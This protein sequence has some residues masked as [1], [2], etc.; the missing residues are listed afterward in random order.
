MRGSILG[1]ATTEPAV[2]STESSGPAARVR[3]RWSRM[4]VV[5][6][7]AVGVLTLLALL[8]PAL[9]P[10]DPTEHHLGD[11]P[12]LLIGMNVAPFRD[13]GVET[14]DRGERRSE[15]PEDVGWIMAVRVLSPASGVIVPGSVAQ[16]LRTKASSEVSGA[17]AS[18]SWLPGTAKIGAR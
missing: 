11:E 2:R 9:A 3:W 13:V 15:R 1:S 7:I 5:S 17:T 16:K 14:D 8:G 18:P 4:G 10:F 12:A 6:L